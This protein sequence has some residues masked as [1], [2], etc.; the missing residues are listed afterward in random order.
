M[1]IN[2]SAPST[3][4]LWILVAVS[5]FAWSFGPICVRYA[6]AFDMHP[7]LVSFGRMVTGFVMFAP[8][9]WYRGGREIAAMPA[10]SRWLALIAGAMSGINIVLMV[11][12]L[13]H[14]SVLI[15]QAFIATIP[16]WVA[17]FEVTLLKQTLG[18]AV[19]IGIFAALAGGLLIA[20]TTGGTSAVIEGGNPTLG[21]AMA[22]ISACSAALYIIVGRKVRGDV[23]FIPYIWL[24]YAAA[25]AV[26]LLI[27]VINGVPL[28]GHDPRGYLWVLLLAVLAQIIGHG[29]LNFVL[30]FIS[31]TTLTMTVQSVPIMS[32][33]WAF[34]IFS[35][36]PTAPQAVGSLIL[37]L[38]VTIVLRGQ[39]QPKKEPD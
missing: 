21:I 9:I 27:T 34:L 26:T 30:R 33:F 36:I 18:K 2:L 35:E 7:A 15:N 11:A 5:A 10:R 14:I 8:Y 23:A 13:E 37:V 38:G 25:A 39:Q 17:F 24:V 16:I 31:P 22:V 28:I 19:W 12:S 29:A 32:A 20:F 3:T 1:R 4:H 6:F